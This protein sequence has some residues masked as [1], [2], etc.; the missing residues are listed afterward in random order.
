MPSGAGSAMAT[1]LPLPDEQPIAIMRYGNKRAVITTEIE[2]HQREIERLRSV[3]EL[4][5]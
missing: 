1:N 2:M 4:A 3:L 5:T